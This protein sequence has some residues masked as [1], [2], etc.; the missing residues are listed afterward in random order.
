MRIRNNWLGYLLAVV[1]IALVTVLYKLMITGVKSPATIA[2]SFL[3]VVLVVASTYGLGPA[4]ICSIVGMLCFNF[5]F[6]PPVGTFTIQDPQNWVALLAFLITAV[7]ASQLSAAARDRASE[8]EKRRAELWKLYQLSRAIIATVDSDTAVSSMARQVVETFDL[9][10]CAV[11]N[12]EEGNRWKRIS[13]GG[14]YSFEIPQP[15]IES[16]FSSS[17]VQQSASSRDVTVAPLKVGVKPIGVLALS[18]RDMELATV[19][20]IAGLVALA[21]ERAR[22]LSEVSHTEALRQS[23]EL[24]SALLASVS[25]DLRTPLTSIRAAVDSLLEEDIVW[26]ADAMREFHVIISEEVNR[27]NRLIQ[28]LLEMARIEGGVINPS[29]QW[30]SLSEIIGNVLLRCEWALREHPVKV[31]VEEK[32]LVNVDS[33]L[34]AQALTNLVEN[35]A[36]YSPAGAEIAIDGG[37]K[38]GSLV[39]SVTDQ[40]IGIPA[41]EIDRVFDKFYRGSRLSGRQTDGTGMGLAIAKG[42]IEA[43]GGN[44]R[45]VSGYGRG[46]TFSLSVPTE[47]RVVSS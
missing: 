41:E 43:H 30:G 5:F 44:I 13:I 23:D 37:V 8:A 45:V 26:D 16:A 18:S 14:Q 17:Q 9:D 4:I 3:I 38:E 12:P 42:I 36:K 19:E 33:R 34:I 10:Y 27:L 7:I 35:A 15:E 28:N 24:K 40:G 39:V 1:G 20:A 22:F 11:F 2:L 25:H 6:L 46:A 32:T 29:R 21:L 31:D 47:S